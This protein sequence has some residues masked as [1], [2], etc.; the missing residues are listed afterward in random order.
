MTATEFRTYWNPDAL[1]VWLEF[2]SKEIEKAP[3]NNITKDFLKAGFPR[4]AA[5]F[6]DFG[7]ISYG[8]KFLNV[9]ELS[10]RLR[11]NDVTKNY[12]ILGS[13]NSGNPICFDASNN[14][15]IILLDHEQGFEPIDTINKTIGE[16]AEC[17]LIYKNFIAR[18]QKENGKRAFLDVNISDVQLSDLK[19]DFEKI[20][21]NIF[22]ESSFWRS[23]INALKVM[24]Q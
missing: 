14:D 12:W 1:N 10:S 21:S 18:V 13:D 8:N 3:L 24:N 19:K 9:F 16:L 7:W 5:P 2:D 20:N 6:L 15:S 4:D 23:E 11:L 22:R 17:L